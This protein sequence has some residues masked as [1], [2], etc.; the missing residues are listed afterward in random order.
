M[1]RKAGKREDLRGLGIPPSPFCLY[2]SV[3]TCDFVY[4]LR[5][6]SFLVHA[7]RQGVMAM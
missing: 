2:V 6:L 5:M 3:N 7:H 1:H 4:L